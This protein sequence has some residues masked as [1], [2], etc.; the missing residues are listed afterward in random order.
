MDD[1]VA[2]QARVEVMLAHATD[3]QDR[4]AAMALRDP[5]CGDHTPLMPPPSP[6]S[7]SED[8]LLS[9]VL[10]GTGG[11]VAAAGRGLTRARSLPSPIERALAMP[12]RMGGCLVHSPD[13]LH[14][15]LGGLQID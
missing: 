6:R 8:G 5:S 9:G 14:L 3:L 4:V 12:K 15:C 2:H 1:E 11:K 10:S 13:V 7:T